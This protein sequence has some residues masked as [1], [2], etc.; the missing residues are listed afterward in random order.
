MQNIFLDKSYKDYQHVLKTLRNF[1][2]Q[3]EDYCII[4]YHLQQAI[5]KLLKGY[6]YAKGVDFK[7]THDIFML[8]KKALDSGFVENTTLQQLAPMLTTWEAT[9]RY[10]I[11]LDL[12]VEDIQ[13]C[14]QLY[15]SLYSWV[16]SSES[17]LETRVSHMLK[18]LGRSDVEYNTIK[19]VLPTA[20]L[21]D[22]SLEAAVK[23]AVQVLYPEQT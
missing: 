10:D 17:D 7:K 5:E 19:N 18:I 23:V 11:C 2:P 13:Q 3:T 14:I 20:Q 16:Q 1:D 4:C 8:Y 9:T 12:N 22:S 6:L 21:D 15:E